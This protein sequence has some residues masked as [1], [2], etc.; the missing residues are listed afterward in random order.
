MNLLQIIREFPKASEYIDFNA[1]GRARWVEAVASSLPT[2]TSVLDV[3][4]GTG[5][6]RSLFAHCDYK[7]QD[8]AQFEGVPAGATAQEWEY[9]TLDYVSDITAIPVEDASFDAIL[10]TEVLEHVPE[11][12]AAIQ[13][14]GRILKPGG[15]LFLS[16]PLGSGIH[17]L[18][19]HFYGGYTPYFYQTMLPRFQLVIDEIKPNGGFFSHFQQEAARAARLIIEKYQLGRFSPLRIL[20]TLLFLRFIPVIFYHLDQNYLVEEFTVGFL[21]TAHK[22]KSIE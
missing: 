13:E 14:M 7:T 8:F 12:I 21:V 19:Y 20:L 18:P 5:R 16:A 6:Y 2:G 4:A 22:S 15:R 11:P 10:C 1:R 3:G 17:Q 9:T